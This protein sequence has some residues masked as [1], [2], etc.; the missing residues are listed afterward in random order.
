MCNCPDFFNHIFY[1]QC[2]AKAYMRNKAIHLSQPRYTLGL[3]QD[4][5]HKKNNRMDQLIKEAIHTHM[6]T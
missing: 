6:T 2:G 3:C 1:A 5:T 4:E